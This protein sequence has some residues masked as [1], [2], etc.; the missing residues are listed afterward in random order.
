MDD[1]SY[2]YKVN[3]SKNGIPDAKMLETYEDLLHLDLSRNKIKNVAI[4]T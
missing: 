1:A 4:F 3:L 2:V